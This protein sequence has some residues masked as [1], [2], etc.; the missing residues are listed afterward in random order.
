MNTDDHNPDSNTPDP[1]DPRDPQPARG[2]EAAPNGEGLLGPIDETWREG[3]PQ[4][5]ARAR[6]E[7]E[8][9]R[10]GL[11]KAT[12]E[13]IYVSDVFFAIQ[14]LPIERHEALL[15]AVGRA[16]GPFAKLRTTYTGTCAGDF[17]RWCRGRFP[18]LLAHDLAEVLALGGIGLAGAYTEELERTVKRAHGRGA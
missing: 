2:S 10:I 3:A 6:I 17:V 14:S 4:P 15:A 12:G 5:E 8:S 16:A 11:P 13:S 9:A 7:L 1:L 18:G